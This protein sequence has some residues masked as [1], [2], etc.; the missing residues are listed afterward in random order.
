MGAVRAGFAR[1]PH[2]AYAQGVLRTAPLPPRPAWTGAVPR[3]PEVIVRDLERLA[4]R[5][6]D[7]IPCLRRAA[8]AARRAVTAGHFDP[9]VRHGLRVRS[10]EAEQDLESACAGAVEAR[11]WARELRLMFPEL[12][13]REFAAEHRQES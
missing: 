2:A 10:R 3:V 9:D 12:R 4:K 5:C 8:K 6:Q 1:S 13:P 11:R 7:A